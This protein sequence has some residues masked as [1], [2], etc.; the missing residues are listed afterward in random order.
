MNPRF[1]LWK[2]LAKV[3]KPHFTIKFCSSSQEW[4]IFFSSIS[5]CD[6][7]NTLN[8]IFKVQNSFVS[9]DSLLNFPEQISYHSIID[10]YPIL[11]KAKASLNAF[12]AYQGGKCIEDLYFGMPTKIDIKMKNQSQMFHIFRK[13]I[14]LVKF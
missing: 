2:M 3:L 14:S 8:D 13:I 1:A 12:G 7:F 9:K 5:K 6:L 4:L 10:S 11:A